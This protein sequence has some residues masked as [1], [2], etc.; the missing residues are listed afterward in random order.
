MAENKEGSST[1]FTDFSIEETS[2]LGDQSII[3]DL[4]GSETVSASPEKVEEIKKEEPKK[5]EK[6]KKEEQKTTSTKEEEV[7]EETNPI[8]DLLQEDEEKEDPSKETKKE[9][10]VDDSSK[11]KEEEP[12]N[13]KFGAL[14][15]DLLKLGVF[16][17]DE[18]E[19][20]VK[21]ESPEDFLE[22]FKYEGE[23]TAMQ[24]INSFLN[25]FGE[26]YQHAFE[27]IYVKGVH[28]KDYF[29]TYN[30]IENFSELDLSKEDNQIQVIKQT[31]LDQGLEQED[32]L[33]EVERLKNYGDLEQVAQ[34]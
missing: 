25:Q 4:L 21:I 23:K 14:A 28:P 19:E 34:K 22:R 2:L 8:L 3:T 9:E 29:E 6:P 13:N 27:A 7:K 31:L 10:T 16:S 33:T 5:E 18:D 15:K 17:L 26:D 30:K 24:K 20:D 11:T 32:V 1:S 12:T